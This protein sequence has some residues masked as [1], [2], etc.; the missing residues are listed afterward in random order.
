MTALSTTSPQPYTNIVMIVL[1]ILTNTILQVSSDVLI[2]LTKAK[3][4]EESGNYCVVQKVM[5]ISI[6]W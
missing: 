1:L 4:D 6:R 2:D 5:E 3:L